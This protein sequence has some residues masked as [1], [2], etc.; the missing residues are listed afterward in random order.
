LADYYL[1]GSGDKGTVTEEGGD[2]EPTDVF[3]A[4]Y[5]GATLSLEAENVDGG[6]ATLKVVECA[7]GYTPWLINLGSEAFPENIISDVADIFADGVPAATN[8]VR[9]VTVGEASEFN[10][11]L[12]FDAKWGGSIIALALVDAEG[13]A[14]VAGAYGSGLGLAGA[15]T[16]ELPAVGGGDEAEPAGKPAVEI[17]ADD[18]SAGTATLKVSGLAEGQ[19]AW[20]LNLGGEAMIENVTSDVAYLF[21]DGDEPYASEMGAYRKVANG[22]Y[23]FN[24]M[25][26][27]DA[28]W[29]GNIIA[30]ATVE[31]GVPTVVSYYVCGQGLTVVGGGSTTVEAPKMA[32]VADKVGAGDGFV[33]LSVSN[34]PAEGTAW[35]LNLGDSAQ[36]NEVSSL[37]AAL[38]EDGDE[39]T[40]SEAGTY[41][42]AEAGK[43]YTFNYLMEYDA[44][45]GGHIIA[46]AIVKDGVPT[47]YAYYTSGVGLSDVEQGGGEEEGED[48]EFGG[49]T[50]SIG[51][52][53]SNVGVGGS[54]PSING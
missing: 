24:G 40:A 8:A 51:G 17:V 13:N 18:A 31:G 3:P 26:E 10:G 41:R 25:L 52:V 12:S 43:E 54:T 9:K 22:E 15:G 49:N 21:E 27:Y 32:V 29:G 33:T 2:D 47:V 50:P 19:N 34:L 23:T 42:L 53:S 5:K 11:L 20:L 30:F 16:I 28:K 39:P 45:W 46:F 36:P 7:D 35:L 37:V 48:V 4:L 14:Y 6:T 44:T 38:F 1:A